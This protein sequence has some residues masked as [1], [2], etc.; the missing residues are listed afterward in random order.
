MSAH[1]IPIEPNWV[2]LLAECRLPQAFAKLQ[3][4]IQKDVEV[5]VAQI[6]PRQKQDYI[7]FTCETLGEDAFVV[8]RNGASIVSKVTF[9]LERTGIVARDAKDEIILTA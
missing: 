6:T 3:Y 4:E 1:E 9:R 5:R 2:E 8:H 7:G